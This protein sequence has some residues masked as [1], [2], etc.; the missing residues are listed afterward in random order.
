MLTATAFSSVVSL[1]TKSIDTYSAMDMRRGTAITPEMNSL[2]I[3]S[4]K[5]IWL[6][7]GSIV[8]ADIAAVGSITTGSKVQLKGLY[9]ENLVWL[10][11]NNTVNGRV[12]ANLSAE[13][14]DNL[15]FK[16]PSWT[17][18]SVYMGRGANVTGDILAGDGDINL[19]RNAVV[20][21]NV[22]GNANI[23][24][25]S[26]GE[27]SGDASP[28]LKGNL[29]TG[30]KVS[31]GGSTEP[32]YADYD[33]VRLASMGPAPDIHAY[34]KK[35]ISGGNK[36]VVNLTAGDYRSISMWGT[37]TELNLSAGTYTLMDLWVGN[38]GTINV[39]TSLG[40]VVLDVHKL[41]SVGNDVTINLIG[42]GDLILN[43]F[44][45]VN[46]GKNVDMTA[47]VLAWNGD[48]ISGDNLNFTG[49]IQA[50]GG[51]SIGSGGVITYSGHVPE[52][53]T[54]AL[55]GLGGAGML[56]RRRWRHRHPHAKR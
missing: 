16:G 42:E 39:D 22:N 35:N 51:V 6:G 48:V 27:I 54:L 9:T 18:K 7:S 43:A 4:G 12:L 38:R 10:S 20:N 36:D 25:D 49:T 5:D 41:F 55:L 14:A 8:D 31:I 30:K 50:A 34:G 15:T 53:A 46:L 52:P 23:W 45:D 26:F 40:D 21:G 2:A 24:I 3:Y 32:A 47:Q 56:W 1:D 17:G 33:T 44:D 11:K 19:D 13:A 28:G 29:S 37:D